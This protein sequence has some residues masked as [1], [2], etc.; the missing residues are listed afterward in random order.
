LYLLAHFN[1]KGINPI[2]FELK[3]TLS[4]EYRTKISGVNLPL[5][6]QAFCL[7]YKQSNTMLLS[8]ISLSMLNAPFAMMPILTIASMINGVTAG[9]VKVVATQGT[10]QGTNTKVNKNK[11]T[12]GGTTAPPITNCNVVV[13]MWRDLGQSTNV[14]QTDPDPTACCSK[15]GNKVHLT[16]GIPGVVCSSDGIVQEL[17]WSNQGL[18]STESTIATAFSKIGELKSLTEL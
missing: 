1:A 17:Q 3:E 11:V 7:V 8:I 9:K 12:S 14:S 15:S 10:T 4:V 16:S 2:R 6:L 18:T 13:Q 5:D